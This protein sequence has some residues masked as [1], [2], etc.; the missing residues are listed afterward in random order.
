VRGVEDDDLP[1]QAQPGVRHLGLLPQRPRVAAADGARQRVHGPPRGLA[2]HAVRLDAEA[3]L[4][5]AQG[6]VGERTE[7]AVHRPGQQAEHDESLLERRDVVASHEGAVR[8]QE[9]TVAE[10]PAC[11]LERAQSLGADDAV[12]H[13]AT[14]LLERA[15]RR[16]EVVVEDVRGDGVERM[17]CDTRDEVSKCDHLLPAVAQ[18]QRPVQGRTVTGVRHPVSQA[19]PRTRGAGSASAGRRSRS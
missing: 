5:L 8:Q 17:R 16:L 12:G 7:D 11:P 14:S 6:T 9:R 10:P 18:T 2:A 13:Q 3:A 1:G 4:E 15:D 19:R